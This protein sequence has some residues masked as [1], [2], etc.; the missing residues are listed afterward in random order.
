[1]AF[2]NGIHFCVGAALGRL[3]TQIAFEE[4][5]RRLGSIRFSPDRNTFAIAPSVAFRAPERLFLEF[6]DREK[7]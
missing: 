7:R 4:I 5:F 6:F 2:G 3:E 1:M